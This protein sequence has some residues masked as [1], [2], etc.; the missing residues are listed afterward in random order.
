MPGSSRICVL[1]LHAV[2]Y[3]VLNSAV[4]ATARMCS[5][6]KA[7]PGSARSAIPGHGSFAIGAD[8]T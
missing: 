3:L 7:Q 6:A 1:P 8:G 2:G 5:Q 4:A